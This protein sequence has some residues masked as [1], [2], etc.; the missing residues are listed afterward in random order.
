MTQQGEHISF[1]CER[2]RNGP[3]RAFHHPSKQSWFNVACRV[4]SLLLVLNNRSK[5]RTNPNVEQQKSK[6]E[7]THAQ[8]SLVVPAEVN[9]ESQSIAC[10]RNRARCLLHASPPRLREHT[11]ACV[12]F[13]ATKHRTIFSHHICPPIPQAL[14]G[15][16]ATPILYTP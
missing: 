2:W 7:H 11:S 13:A 5:A 15:R 12:L 4:L 6:R 10:S 8:L 1:E 16:S 9:L 3:T 14:C